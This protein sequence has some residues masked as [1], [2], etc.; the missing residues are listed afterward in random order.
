M[1]GERT[2]HKAREKNFMEEEFAFKKRDLQIAGGVLLVVILAVAG[3][4]VFAQKPAAPAVPA[5][6]SPMV[7]VV[8]I[9]DSNCKDCF[10]LT[11]VVSAIKAGGAKVGKE[12][13]VEFTSGTGKDLIAKYGITKIPSMVVT[14]AINSSGVKQVFSTLGEEKQGAL[15]LT[16]PNPV[17]IDVQSGEAKGRI[18]LTYLKDSACKDCGDYT[19]SIAQ[20]KQVGVVISSEKSVEYSSPEGKALLQKYNIT[21]VPTLLLSKDAAE[22]G[23]LETVWQQIGSIEADG[24]HV[25][26]TPNPPYVE[27]A[28]GVVKGIVSLVILADSECAECYDTSLHRQSLESLG[29][30]IGNETA[31]EFNSTEG[32]AL[33]KKYAI[34]AVPTMLI[35][36]EASEYMMLTQLW[37]Q[38]GSFEP[39]GWLVFRNMDAMASAIYR[40]ATSG[41]VVR[42]AANAPAGAA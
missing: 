6:S 22:Y 29:I 10:N 37:P 17:Y 11:E 13:A 2:H 42:P 8:K 26:R 27:V 34:T 16:K 20:L 35:S 41:Q 14:G 30:K 28:T 31:I 32:Q 15:V 4:M 3:F 39:D 21:N 36:P 25:I 1:A 24:T 38:V 19:A 5:D 7:N 33:V 12:E 9:I 23:D 18:S 40:N